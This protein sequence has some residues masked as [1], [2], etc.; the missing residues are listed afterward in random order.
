MTDPRSTAS[1]SN[2]ADNIVRY[3]VEYNWAAGIDFSLLQSVKAGKEDELKVSLALCD[4]KNE[5]E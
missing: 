4:E 5:H 3:L 1:K 2:S